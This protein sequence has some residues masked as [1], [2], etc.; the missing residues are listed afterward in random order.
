MP[1]FTSDRPG[2]QGRERIDLDRSLLTPPSLSSENWALGLKASR[3]RRPKISIQNLI[4]SATLTRRDAAFF[5]LKS[6]SLLESCPINAR[7]GGIRCLGIQ[8]L[9]AFHPR[10]SRISC[11]ASSI[12]LS[13]VLTRKSPN[14][15]TAAL[16]MCLST[17]FQFVL[18]VFVGFSAGN[19]VL[20]CGRVRNKLTNRDF[21]ARRC[22]PQRLQ[23][24]LAVDAYRENHFQVCDSGKIGPHGTQIIPG[25]RAAKFRVDASHFVH[26]N[27]GMSDVH[28]PEI[29][30]DCIGKSALARTRRTVQNKYFRLVHYWPD[31][32][33]HAWSLASPRLEATLPNLTVGRFCD[34]WQKSQ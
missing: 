26:I 27:Y 14:L 19:P 5:T 21:F 24:F 20:Q 18:P 4:D 30:S 13:S 11:D 8:S 15:S 6:R 33:S 7:R 1:R 3:Y 10:R 29:F 17:R 16:L 32:L 9:L 31:V 23:I 12:D 34:A 28:L 25:E 2:H 22:I